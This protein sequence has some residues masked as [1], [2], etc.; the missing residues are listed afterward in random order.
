VV[1]LHGGN[2]YAAFPGLLEA[3]L[4]FGYDAMLSRNETQSYYSLLTGNT[5]NPA[6][7][8]LLRVLF[9][10]ECI[11][12]WTQVRSVLLDS[13]GSPGLTVRMIYDI[14]SLRSASLPFSNSIGHNAGLVPMSGAQII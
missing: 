3:V 13:R 9:V 7:N 5:C 14:D 8:V 2:P 11:R 10:G 1:S 6:C 4:S 12:R